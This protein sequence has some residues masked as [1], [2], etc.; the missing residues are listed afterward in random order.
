MI[1]PNCR[2]RRHKQNKEI[3]STSDPRTAASVIAMIVPRDRCDESPEVG[4]GLVTR[5]ALRIEDRES[6]RSA[7]HEFEEAAVILTEPMAKRPS[8]SF[9]IV[10]VWRKL[11]LSPVRKNSVVASLADDAPFRATAV[12]LSSC[13]ENFPEVTSRKPKIVMAEPSDSG[14]NYTV[15][16][17]L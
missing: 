14:T 16:R 7:T 15:R 4:L 17:G 6:R 3:K 12:S 1:R 2:R 11:L 5:L 9:V 8:S 13:T 10:N